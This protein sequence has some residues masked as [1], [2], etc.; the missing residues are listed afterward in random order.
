MLSLRFLLPDIE[1][2]QFDLVIL[3]YFLVTR[4]QV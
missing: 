4:N 2:K 3:S 1:N